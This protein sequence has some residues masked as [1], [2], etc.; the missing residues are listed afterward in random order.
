MK[1]NLNNNKE[2]ARQVDPLDWWFPKSSVMLD[3]V[4]ERCST[5]WTLYVCLK[6]PYN[7]NDIKGSYYKLFEQNHIYRL[8]IK[9]PFVQ[10]NNDYNNNYNLIVYT[11]RLLEYHNIISNE[12]KIAKQYNYFTIDLFNANYKE[13]LLHR[14]IYYMISDIRAY[15][16]EGIYNHYIIYNSITL[17]KYILDPIVIEDRII[18]LLFLDKLDIK[19]LFLEPF[20][21]LD[22]YSI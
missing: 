20:E 5:P 16:S 4:I 22:N 18:E 11:K 12:I 3:D 15:L 7:I 17:K 2:R 8:L 6:T 13:T 1:F 14:S 21:I 10:L 9:S 19:L